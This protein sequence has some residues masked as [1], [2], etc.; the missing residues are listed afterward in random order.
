MESSLD[1]KNNTL[2]S[3]LPS[4]SNVEINANSA[5]FL[6]DVNQMANSI[7]KVLRKHKVKT[8][9]KSFSKM[10]HLLRKNRLNPFS[11][12]VVI[13]IPCAAAVPSTLA[14]YTSQLKLF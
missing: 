9:F 5:A 4:F 8:V 2:S 3:L 1:L 11:S 14:E 10:P 6:P 12:E 13:S 7:S